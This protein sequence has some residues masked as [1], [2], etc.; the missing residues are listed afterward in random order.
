M[1]DD[2]RKIARKGAASLEGVTGAQARV[3]SG[4]SLAEALHHVAEAERADLLVVATSARRRIAGHQPGSVAERIVHHSP[5]AVAVVPPSDEDPRF[6]RIGVAV[7]G[8]PGALIA[9]EY[10]CR[11]VDQAGGETSKLR[12]L[13][14]SPLPGVFT[15]VPQ[16]GLPAPAP[17]PVFDRGRLEELAAEA[18]AHGEV[19]VVEQAGEPA[20]ELVRM[21]AGL[22]VLVTGSR[23]QGPFKRL[24]LGSVSTHVVRHA[25]CPVI[26]V[27]AVT[28]I[29]DGWMTAS[30]RAAGS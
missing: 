28:G 7:D 5:C 21:S 26:V 11:L 2:A 10:A 17:A 4:P 13:H 25:P 3:A 22:D 9:L 23:D 19:D 24:V 12:L 20:A 14:V 15:H 1:R 27:P 30:A 6:E 18:A 29:T 8:T 16:P